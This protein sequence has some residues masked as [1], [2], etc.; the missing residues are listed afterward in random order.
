MFTNDDI[1][2]AL[3]TT[4]INSV[5]TYNVFAKLLLRLVAALCIH[6]R[7]LMG[8]YLELLDSQDKLYKVF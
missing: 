8:T 5:S 6:H 2:V 1:D 4:H 7:G 3:I